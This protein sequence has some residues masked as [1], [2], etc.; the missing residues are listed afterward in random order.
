MGPRQLEFP[1]NSAGGGF[2]GFIV[3]AIDVAIHL[4]FVGMIEMIA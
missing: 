3:D 2:R 1:P 4:D